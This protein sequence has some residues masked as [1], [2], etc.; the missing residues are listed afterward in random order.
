MSYP[1]VDQRHEDA[2]ACIVDHDRNNG[3]RTRTDT[4]A[5]A[6]VAQE[7]PLWEQPEIPTECQGDCIGML[8]FQSKCAKADLTC[9]V[10]LCTVSLSAR[11]QSSD[12]SLR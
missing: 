5:V 1:D 8:K 9:L 12:R 11:R 7:Q 4:P 3:G 2:S 10:E 6:V